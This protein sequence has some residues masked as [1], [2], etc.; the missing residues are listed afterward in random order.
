MV[1]HDDA[2][3]KEATSENVVVAGTDKTVQ[4]FHPQ[5]CKPPRTE[6]PA[7]QQAIGYG[8]RTQA[9]TYHHCRATTK[10]TSTTSQPTA[11]GRASNQSLQQRGHRCR[12]RRDMPQALHRTRLP[13]QEPPRRAA[14]TL[15]P[16]KPPSDPVLPA[17]EHTP[18]A[19]KLTNLPPEPANRRGRPPRPRRRSNRAPPPDP[20][21]STIDPAAHH[22]SG[23]ATC[24][25]GAAGHQGAQI[26]ETRAQ[27][28]R[29]RRPRPRA[30][31]ARRRRGG[32]IGWWWGRLESPDTERHGGEDDTQSL[33]ICPVTCPLFFLIELVVV[34]VS[35]QF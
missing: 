21:L 20:V 18:L 17:T 3:K 22:G 19:K 25:T 8:A 28:R 32:R 33:G 12:R 30:G 7:S 27:S 31:F 34:K 10:P 11:V 13:E 15:D 16:A 14:P 1:L 5:H 4:G 6:E 24:G 9:T 26:E 23:T 29:P 35:K 2:F